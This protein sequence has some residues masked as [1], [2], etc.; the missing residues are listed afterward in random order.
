M[1]SQHLKCVLHRASLV[2][3]DCPN[4]V[5]IRLASSISS[6]T[7]LFFNKKSEKFDH[8]SGLS[9]TLAVAAV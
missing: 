3:G 9:R 4:A 1:N 7:V 8:G 6:S 2:Q 5:Q